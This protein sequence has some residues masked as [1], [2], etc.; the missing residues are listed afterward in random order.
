MDRMGIGEAGNSSSGGQQA[1]DFQNIHILALN[2]LQS[3]IDHL[4]SLQPETKR[5]VQ[6]AKVLVSAEQTPVKLL[7]RRPTRLVAGVHKA[8]YDL[9]V[10]AAASCEL[11]E[12]TLYVKLH[13]D[14]AK[15]KDDPLNVALHRA[16]SGYPP[17]QQGG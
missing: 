15:V 2:N 13:D 7:I 8:F 16:W 4:L 5:L 12:N 9:S 10:G 17:Q 6:K 11:R 14:S 1:N 3:K